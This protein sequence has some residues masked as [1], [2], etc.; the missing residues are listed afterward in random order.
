M[1]RQFKA[2]HLSLLLHALFLW[3]ALLLSQHTQT[4]RPPVALDFSILAA[5]GPAEDSQPATAQEIKPPPPPPPIA[6]KV[7]P[8]PVAKKTPQP[9]AITKKTVPSVEE[10]TPPV[11]TVPVAASVDTSESPNN[12]AVAE[13]TTPATAQAS[14]AN[15]GRGG[16]NGG[17]FS[18][19]QL[20]GPLAVL[21]KSPPVYPSTAKR[22]NIEGWIKIKF[23]VDEHG[24]VSH[25]S[26]LAAEPEGVFEQSV[27][28]C[29]GNWRFK[30]GT[31][32][33]MAVK[34]Q[35]EQTITFKLEG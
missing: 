18:V 1:N 27:L 14:G 23:V 8:K 19:G 22:R 4:M 20:D 35:V 3:G 30:P 26:V 33:G 25:I 31:V 7:M 5:G 10:K 13:T 6:K 16:G 32:K 34:A 15:Q 11:E 21:A 9:Q 28:Q 12:A 24:H 17:L 2:T 29:V